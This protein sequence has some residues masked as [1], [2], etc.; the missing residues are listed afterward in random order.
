MTTTEALNSFELE[1]R[2]LPD[3]VGVGFTD[4]D[5]GVT[6]HVLAPGSATVDELR[7]RV[8]Q[9]GRVFLEQ[10]VTVEVDDGRGPVSGSAPARERIRLLAVRVVADEAEVEVHLGFQGRRTVGR[11]PAGVPTGAAEATIEAIDRLGAKIP[12]RVQEVVSAGTPDQERVVVV[13]GDRDGGETRH[14]VAAG[15]DLELVTARATLHALNR[16][17]EDASVFHAPS[18]SPVPATPSGDTPPLAPPGP[19]SSTS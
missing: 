7:H 1:L 10:P 5:D 15:S 2:R 3:V 12:F 9:L 17:V 8:A 4:N 16:Y 11:G 19:P 6:V 14:G 13:L 18:S